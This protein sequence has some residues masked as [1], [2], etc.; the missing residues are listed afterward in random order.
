MRKNGIII[1]GQ[2]FNYK[3]KVKDK[4]LISKSKHL[5]NFSIAYD[6]MV[7]AKDTGEELTSL[8]IVYPGMP[9]CDE[10]STN[11]LFIRSG[12]EDTLLAKANH[13]SRSENQPSQFFYTFEEFDNAKNK[14]KGYEIDYIKGLGSLSPDEYKETVITNPKEVTITLD[15]MYKESL[16][17]AFGSESQLR[18]AWLTE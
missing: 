4:E 8:C 15:E 12:E 13:L 11:I 10:I 18:K 14:L 6:L 7:L 17:K 5:D 16:E 1:E 2:Y 3:F 9:I